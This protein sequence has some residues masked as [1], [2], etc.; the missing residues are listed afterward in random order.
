MNFILAFLPLVVFLS[1]VLI[2]KRT[3][4]SSAII[5][6]IAVVVITFFGWGVESGRIISA[7]VKGV[8]LSLDI[9]TIVFGSILIFEILQKKNLFVF[10]K[11]F[12]ETISKDKRVHIVLVAWSLV[13]FLEGVAGFG[14]PIMI[15]APILVV[16]GFSPLTAVML[17]LI[18]DSV[19]DIFG[20][21]GLP[22]TLGIGSNLASLGVDAHLLR[23]VSMSISAF[24]I[25]ASIII[26]II[27]L[28]VF[29]RF[30]KK[31]LSHVI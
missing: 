11:N 25:A 9:A 30:E 17:P 19:P 7:S 2:F 23:E 15:A 31:P 4:L 13:Y 6:F 3:I 12:F 10:I 29:A 8:L 18:G 21:I 14:T 16:L 5:S 28:F 22:V 26:P 1:L 20:A 27:M 24:N